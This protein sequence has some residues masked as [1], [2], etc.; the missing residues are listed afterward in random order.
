MYYSNAIQQNTHTRVQA[1]PNF[2]DKYS[3]RPSSRSTEASLRQHMR[4]ACKLAW[5]LV[6][7]WPPLIATTPR[8]YRE[9]WH[10]REFQ[11]WDKKAVN[12]KL[13]YT[14]PVLFCSYEGCVGVKGWVGN[15]DVSSSPRHTPPS[16]RAVRKFRKSW[17]ILF[18]LIN[19]NVCVCESVLHCIVLYWSISL[20]LFV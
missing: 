5:D 1:F 17:Q 10:D 20:L 8:D 6:T 7:A 14:R 13:F 16:E 3:I 15:K 12:F 18:F 2:L 19:M 11:Y 9:E 4:Q